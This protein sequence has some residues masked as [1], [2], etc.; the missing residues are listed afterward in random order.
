MFE[1]RR[2]TGLAEAARYSLLQPK[3]NWANRTHNPAT[4]RDAP[5]APVL[6][7]PLPRPHSLHAEAAPTASALNRLQV[8]S[9]SGLGRLQ[10]DSE[11]APGRGTAALMSLPGGGAVRPQGN[12]WHLPQAYTET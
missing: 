8:G 1:S 2:T 7:D 4:V 6:A 9:K 3:L 10:I 5:V 12:R 11:W